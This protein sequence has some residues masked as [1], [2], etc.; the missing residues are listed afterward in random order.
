MRIN[1]KLQGLGFA[2]KRH[3]YNNYACIFLNNYACCFTK[4]EKENSTDKENLDE[5]RNRRIG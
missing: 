3:G 1:V 4:M 5:A 2:E